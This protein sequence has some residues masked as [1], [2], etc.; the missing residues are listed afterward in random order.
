M[1]KIG[2]GPDAEWVIKL[3]E[4][5]KKWRI[6]LFFFITARIF[7]SAVIH[8]M[9]VPPDADN[10]SAEIRKAGPMVQPS[11]PGRLVLVKGQK[12]I[13]GSLQIVYRGLDA[14]TVLIDVT[15]VELDPQY[16][17]QHRLSMKKAKH[18]FQMRG[19]KFRL[20]SATPSRLKI[21]LD[22]A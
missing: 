22:N 18:G 15:L 13:L 21:A 5:S 12:Q 14:D 4:S 7:V 8:I 20:M 1:L 11:S 3:A 6:P 19:Q 17:Y 16:A 9:T 10:N 2:S